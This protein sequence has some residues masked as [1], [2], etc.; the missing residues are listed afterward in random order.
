[1]TGVVTTGTVACLG[2]G[3][4]LHL[5][6]RSWVWGPREEQVCRL[7][8][9]SPQGP[10]CGWTCVLSRPWSE[11]MAPRTHTGGHRGLSALGGSMRSPDTELKEEPIQKPALAPW[12]SERCNPEPSYMLTHERLGVSGPGKA[13]VTHTWRRVMMGNRAETS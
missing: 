6:S 11:P 8:P 2:L 9:T 1:M 5:R 3:A 4:L 12:R 7:V 10:C 13:P